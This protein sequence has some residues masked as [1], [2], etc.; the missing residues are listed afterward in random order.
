MNQRKVLLM[1]PFKSVETLRDFAGPAPRPETA[2]S[3]LLRESL[4]LSST[5][6]ALQREYHA[7]FDGSNDIE[8]DALNRQ[9]LRARRRKEENGHG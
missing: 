6:C 3:V 4:N 5:G 9:I 2:L 1:H 8:V 7:I